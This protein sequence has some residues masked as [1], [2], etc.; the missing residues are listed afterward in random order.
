MAQFQNISVKDTLK[1]MAQENPVLIDVRPR[2]A[3]NQS[4]IPSAIHMDSSNLFERLNN[5]NHDRPV[6]FYCTRGVASKDAA[7]LFSE[8]G[9][10]NVYSLEGGYLAWEDAVSSGGHDHHDGCCGGH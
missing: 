4:N 8:H 6:I 7:Q 10:K 2:D 5:I 9:F 3:Y 1:L